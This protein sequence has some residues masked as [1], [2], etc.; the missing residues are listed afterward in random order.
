[1]KKYMKLSNIQIF[2]FVNKQI[3]GIETKVGELGSLVSGGQLQDLELL[4]LFIEI[5]NY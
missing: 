5:Q 4:E 2:D 3:D 1:M